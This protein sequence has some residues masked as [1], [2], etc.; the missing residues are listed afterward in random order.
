MLDQRNDDGP[1]SDMAGIKSRH[2]CRLAIDIQ[3][4]QSPLVNGKCCT[5]TGQEADRLFCC[6]MQC[7]GEIALNGR[8]QTQ[9]GRPA[10][11]VNRRP[12]KRLYHTSACLQPLS[13]QIGRKPCLNSRRSPAQRGFKRN[14]IPLSAWLCGDEQVQI[15]KRFPVPCATPPPASPIPLPIAQRPDRMPSGRWPRK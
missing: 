6:C 14:E 5:S 7:L 9:S 4:Q 10:T 8:Q 13:C 3:P 12:L 15:L 2:F 11:Y 1:E